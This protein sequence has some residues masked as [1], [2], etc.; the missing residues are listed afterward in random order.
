MAMRYNEAMPVS[1][2]LGPLDAGILIAYVIVLASIGWWAAHRTSKTTEEYFLANRSIPWLVTTAS[3][4]ATCI[5]ALTFI[6]TPAEGYASDYRFLLS[7]P[8]DI[9]ATIFIAMVFLPHFQKLRVTSIYQAVA[10]RFGPPAR[11]TCSAYFLLTRSLA[12]TVRIVA[13]A[14]VLEVVSGGGISYPHCVIIVV[15][16]ILAYTTL[17]GGR[18]IAWTD[19]VQ[20]TL[21]VTGAVS[22]LVYIVTHVPGGIPAIIEAGRH[23][24]RPDGS[25]YNKFNFLEMYKPAN[26]G[27]LFL[28]TIWG[29]F[30]SSAAY[31]TDQDMV[32]RLLACNDNRKARWSLMAWGLAGIPI[33]FLFLSIGVALYAYAQVHPELVAGMTDNDHVFPRFILGAMPHGLRGLLLAAVAS[34]AMGSADSAM[35]SLSTA[36]TMDFY[37]PFWGKGASDAHMVKVSK[38]SFVAFGLFFMVCAMALRRLDNLL[39]LAFRI[40][41]FTYGPL[42]GIFIVAI[43]TDWKLSAR[44]VLGLMLTPTIL[45][46]GLAMIAWALSGGGGFW[47]ELHKTYWRLY[48]IFGTLFVPMG[49]WLLKEPAQ[50][51]AVRPI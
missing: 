20:F 42:L 16:G 19:L 30:N 25:V 51:P 50:R 17:G 33:T 37:K 31:G 3:F 18:A 47:G 9:L 35:A 28:M 49:A 13:I 8:G 4:V 29:F 14:K 21:L 11:T 23:A 32:Q 48:T 38:L 12:S 5:S 10:E 40:I 27:L 7:N 46:F 24:V 15:G 6:G 22:A 1:L 26:I 41:A 45:T 44:K 43:M 39:W 36:F 34:A 2:S